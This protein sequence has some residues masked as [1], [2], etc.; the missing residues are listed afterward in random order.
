MF[1][2]GMAKGLK[3]T[4]EH[5]FKRP[6]TVQYPEEVLPLPTGYRGRVTLVVN[7]ET[8]RYRCTACGLCAKACPVSIIQIVRA[9]DESGK[10]TPYPERFEYNLL[11]CIVCGLCVEACP[12]EALTMSPER[13]LAVYSR[14]AADQNREK[15]AVM[16]SAEVDEQRARIAGFGQMK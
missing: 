11:E 2:S 16:A 5:L 3:T 9:R 12:F 1:G 6:V 7:P 14:K 13:E 8:N 15:M 4:L 10:P